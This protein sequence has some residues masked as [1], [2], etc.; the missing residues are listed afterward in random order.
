MKPLSRIFLVFLAA[1][2][3]ASVAGCGTSDVAAKVNGEVIKLSEVDAQ[4]ASVSEQ[5]PQMFQG[6]DGEVREIDYRQRILENLITAAL[7]RQYAEE[8]GI[9]VSE[10]DI[11]AAVDEQKNAFGGDE[12]AF[13]S[14][15]ESV[16]MD[17]AGYRKQI[18]EQLLTRRIIESISETVT[19]TEDDIADYYEKEKA[20]Y[21]N[22]AAKRASHILVAIEDKATAEKILE[23]VRSGGNFESL[24]RQ[25]SIDQTSASKGGDLGWPTTPYVPEFTAAVEELDVGEVSD[26]VET[27]FGWHIIKVTDEREQEVRALADVSSEIEVVLRSQLQADRYQ[28]LVNDLRDKAEIE[29]FVDFSKDAGGTEEK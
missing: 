27:V 29:Y 24:A 2:M 15:L 23:E 26:L 6:V 20:T 19:V 9:A 5:Y 28:Q 7:V 4:F 17:L 3:V 22:A 8:E 12:E 14:S 18:S 16:G 13:M 10:S 11:D 1:S 25:Y 21:T